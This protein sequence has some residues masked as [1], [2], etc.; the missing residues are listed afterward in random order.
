MKRKKKE[1]KTQQ[2]IIFK[3]AAL[4]ADFKNDPFLLSDGNLYLLGG[5]CQRAF[6]CNQQETIPRLSY[7]HI[8]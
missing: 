7:F 5:F 2:L 6:V 1:K 3:I 4:K 8:N